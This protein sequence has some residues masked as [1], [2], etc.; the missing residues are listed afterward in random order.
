M[1]D[2]SEW[3]QILSSGKILCSCLDTHTWCRPMWWY[4][5]YGRFV[6]SSTA[7]IIAAKAKC[8][9]SRLHDFLHVGE[10]K[11][12]AASNKTLHFPFLIPDT[13]YFQ[14]PTSD[15]LH[16]RE[17]A[18]LK[19]NQN[20]GEKEN[21][22]KIDRWNRI[23]WRLIHLLLLFHSAK[24]HGFLSGCETVSYSFVTR[25]CQRLT[26]WMLPTEV[27][28]M[29]WFYTILEVGFNIDSNAVHARSFFTST[30]LHHSNSAC[31]V[32]SRCLSVGETGAY[33]GLW[34]PS[35]SGNLTLGWSFD[36]VLSFFAILLFCLFH[37]CC[38]LCHYSL[39]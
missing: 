2:S 38:G 19:W 4:I 10:E 22:S 6:R 9:S 17:T 5:E 3:N 16:C 8:A 21:T 25:M 14:L 39:Q 35:C 29:Q 18:I 37:S 30:G 34:T 20:K 24:K 31:G 26:S 28:I 33:P 15:C 13:A 12:T 32:S 23:I 7:Y 1:L 11:W 36:V 27:D